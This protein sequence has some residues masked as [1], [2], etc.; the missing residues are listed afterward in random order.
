MQNKDQ[1]PCLGTQDPEQ[2]GTKEAGSLSCSRALRE[3][4]PTYLKKEI[5]FY[6]SEMA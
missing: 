5:H 4:V 1:T 2:C 6:P 3:A